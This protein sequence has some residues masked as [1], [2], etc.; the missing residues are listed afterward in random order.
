MAPPFG[1]GLGGIL[2]FIH[3]VFTAKSHRV[4]YR[5]R[6]V[7]VKGY[8]HMYWTPAFGLGFSGALQP[9]ETS[10]SLRRCTIYKHHR[11]VSGPHQR[12]ASTSHNPQN[13][14]HPAKRQV[15]PS[16]SP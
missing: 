9:W 11:L 4:Y 15:L 6:V 7:R 12:H 16:N 5:H 3:R 13:A 1:G 14:R 2:P 10:T 8:M